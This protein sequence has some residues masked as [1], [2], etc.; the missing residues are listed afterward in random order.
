MSALP[1]MRYSGPH[2]TDSA[3]RLP[4][5]VLLCSS[6]HLLTYSVIC[7]LSMFP[8]RMQTSWG[9]GLLLLSLTTLAFSPKAGTVPDNIVG[10]Q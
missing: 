2:A 10:I 8:T 9:K 5:S 7:L 6:Y 3:R 4:C 1:G